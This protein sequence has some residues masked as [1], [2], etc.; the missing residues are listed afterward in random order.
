MGCTADALIENV[1]R[2]SRKQV[3][4]KIPFSWLWLHSVYPDSIFS[5]RYA[6]QHDRV[7]VSP[8]VF[9]YVFLSKMYV[10]SMMCFPPMCPA[11]CLNQRELDQSIFKHLDVFLTIFFSFFCLMR[12]EKGFSE[13]NKL[14]R[15]IR[16]ECFFSFNIFKLR[17]ETSL[18]ELEDQSRSIFRGHNLHD[19]QTHQRK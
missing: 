6:F 15:G 8:L 3:K 11:K 9:F 1:P 7:S 18:R 16:K 19:T 2:R 14:K 17:S 4:V 10:L 5:S 13:Y 12:I